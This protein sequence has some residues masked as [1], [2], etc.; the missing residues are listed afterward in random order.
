MGFK[1]LRYFRVFNRFGQLL[2]E[3]K[4]NGAGWDGSFEGQPLPTQVVVWIAEGV[5]VDGHLYLRKGT[6]TVVR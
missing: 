6:S 4:T 5:G 2:F 3:T 1:E